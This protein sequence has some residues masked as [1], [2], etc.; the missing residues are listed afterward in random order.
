MS[1]SRERATVKEFAKNY[2]RLIIVAQEFPV[3]G[4][5]TVARGPPS[6]PSSFFSWSFQP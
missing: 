3:V 2:L 1:P 4:F 6:S 5:F